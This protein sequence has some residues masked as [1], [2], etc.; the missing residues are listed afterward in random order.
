MPTWTIHTVVW[1]FCRNQTWGFFFN[2]SRKSWVA[3]QRIIGNN[4]Q[5]KKVEPSQRKSG[6]P[7]AWLPWRW[8]SVTRLW[9]PRQNTSGSLVNRRR[10][11]G[12]RRKTR[13]LSA[14]FVEIQKSCQPL[15]R[16]GSFVQDECVLA[17]TDSDLR[18]CLN[19]LGTIEKNK[20]WGGGGKQKEKQVEHFIWHW[21]SLTLVRS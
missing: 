19:H 13:L 21:R 3:S 2:S 4:C 1:V 6:V 11:P 20:G 8:K 9:S 18:L 17:L 15:F 12:K 14:Q 16:C 5:W 10:V 7:W